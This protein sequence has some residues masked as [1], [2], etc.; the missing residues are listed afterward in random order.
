MQKIVGVKQDISGKIFYYLPP[1]S[2]YNIGDKVVFLDNDLEL[3][4]TI[5][6]KDK[7]VDDVDNL[8]RIVRV[9][10]PADLKKAEELREKANQAVTLTRK[11]AKSLKLDMKVVS[12]EYVL[13]ASKIIISFTAEDRVDFRELL[14]ELA[15]NL[16]TRIELK[17]IGQRDEVKIVGGLGPCGEICC[18][19]R[20]LKDFEH[21]TVK[22]AK[23]QGL[24]LSPTKISGLC[25]R[26]MCCLGYEN[27]Y[28]EEVL[29]RMPKVNS[30]VNT[31]SGKGQVI[32]NDI[33][34]EQVS[35]KFVKDDESVEITSFPLEEIKQDKKEINN[36]IQN[37]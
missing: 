16:K 13:D 4:G 27:P 24:S 19:T 20:F 33:L 11:K 8:S 35:V 26:L 37:R 17:Q 30:F 22:M 2:A 9:A 21:F 31:P 1:N 25:G 14:K 32:Y 10:T 15:T 34:R 6:F 3:L 36:G 5:I 28:Y 12:A 23:N 18:C 7:D 29:K